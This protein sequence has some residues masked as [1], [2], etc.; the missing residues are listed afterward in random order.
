MMTAPVTQ[1]A[2]A[3]AHGLVERIKTL[4]DAL[5]IS[6]PA[7]ARGM[8]WCRTCGTVAGVD[9]AQAFRTGWPKCC[10]ATMTIDP[11]ALVAGA[12]LVDELRIAA[13]R[14]GL[15]L[16]KFTSGLTPNGTG[17][18][19]NMLAKV[20]CPSARTVDRVRAFIDA[21]VGQ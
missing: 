16:W 2:V 21:S 15:S 8:V 12:Q 13:A 20:R 17:A 3:T 6:H 5:A 4:P 7:L 11:P 10:G 19:L 14:Q 9:A 18:W 1:D